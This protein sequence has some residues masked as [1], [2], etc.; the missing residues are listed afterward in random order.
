M[1]ILEAIANL[2]HNIIFLY[3][4]VI[5]ISAIVSWVN[6]D[7]YNP[8]VQILYKLTEPL[9]QKIRKLMPTTISGIDLTPIIVLLI[10]NFIDY[11]LLAFIN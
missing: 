4:W 3:T 11:I 5:I 9:Y 10:L 6:P 8:I 1:I 7:P 2:I